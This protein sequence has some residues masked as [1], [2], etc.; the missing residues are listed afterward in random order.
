MPGKGR[1]CKILRNE[2]SKKKVWKS[3][4]TYCLSAAEPVGCRDL[5]GGS[6]IAAIQKNKSDVG[7]RQ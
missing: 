7:S 3:L 4:W 2:D 5:W 6:R 1:G